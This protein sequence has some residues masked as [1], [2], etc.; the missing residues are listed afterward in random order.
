MDGREPS[1]PPAQRLDLEGFSEDE[2]SAAITRCYGTLTSDLDP[3]LTVVYLVEER[4]LN[5]REA[6]TVNQVPNPMSELLAMLHDKGKYKVLI[7]ALQ[8]TAS[9]KKEHHSQL[10]LVTKHLLSAQKSPIMPGFDSGVSSNHPFDDGDE[11]VG[12]LSKPPADTIN[13]MGG[14]LGIGDRP[15]ND[16]HHK[17]GGKCT[18]GCQ[19]TFGLGDRLKGIFEQRV[20]GHQGRGDTGGRHPQRTMLCTTT[21][22]A[23]GC[24]ME[25]PMH[26]AHL[27]TNCSS[28]EEEEFEHI[29]AP[30]PGNGAE[31]GLGLIRRIKKLFK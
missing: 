18:V 11:I 14:Q 27:E 1:E 3:K 7:E 16:G 9:R 5:M 26:T 6:N 25:A 28:S 2:C 12:P 20:D 21:G 19:E 15:K 23:S 13:G 4:H 22:S 8:H 10:L 17:R 29:E 31:K 30:L 24:A